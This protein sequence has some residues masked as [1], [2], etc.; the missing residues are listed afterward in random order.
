MADGTIDTT[1][2][3][4]TRFGGYTNVFP[5]GGWSSTIEVYLDMSLAT[6]QDQRFAYTVAASAPDCLHRRDFVFSVGTKP[7]TPG[8]F[9]MS[10]SN[11]S[12][13][14]PSDPGRSPLTV[15]TT[16]W[17]TF[18]HTFADNG[19]G[20]LSVTMSVNGPGGSSSWTL[21]DPTDVIGT[22]VGGSRYGWFS[23]GQFSSLAIQNN[24]LSR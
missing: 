14:W 19:S 8:S 23:Y 7:G 21:S 24:S 20:V 1:A 5:T 12:P 9:I 6:G 13:G 15:S 2:G 17:Y 22:T 18:T 4:F 11:N 3:P 16:G 10:A